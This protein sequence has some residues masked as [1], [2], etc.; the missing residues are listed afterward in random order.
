MNK[1]T[2]RDVEVNG[3]TVFCRVD[4]NVPMSDGEV[5]DDTRIK[6]ALPTIQHLTGNGAKSFLPVTWDDLKE[7]RYR[8]FVLI[9]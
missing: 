5:T 6:A 7:K 1:Q 2:I 3:K 4:F 8:S 9:L